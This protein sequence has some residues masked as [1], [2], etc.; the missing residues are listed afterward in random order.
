MNIPDEAHGGAYRQFPTRPDQY[1][2]SAWDA[3]L[4]QLFSTAVTHATDRINWY[5]A[6]ATERAAVAKR[7]RF[8]SL[9]LF[10]LGTLAPILLTFLIKIAAV[11]KTPNTP[12]T[13]LDMIA[14]LPLAEIGYVL[15][16]VAGAL[17]VF[18]QFFDASGSWIRFRQSQARLEVLL[19]DFRFSWAQAMAQA[20][21]SLIGKERPPSF[22]AILRDF[23]IKV[24]WLAEDET[25]Q[26]AKR[27]S[28]MIDTFDRNP[29]LK[30]SLGGSPGAQAGA[31]PEAD[32]DDAGGRAG[33]TN[34]GYS[35]AATSQRSPP[36]AAHEDER[37][38]TVNVRLAI[39]GIDTLDE[40]SLRLE[41]DGTQIDVAGDGFVELQLAPGMDHAIVATGQRAQKAVRAQLQENVTI[42][43]E[44]KPLTIML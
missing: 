15:L 32:A 28:Q 21:G 25:K 43:D 27:F 18:D 17:V 20:Q 40:G 3:T 23:V 29:N 16:A 35:A 12:S 24:E 19:A 36:P 2:G 13:W 1:R 30:V 39:D 9:L 33:T 11:G 22:T 6:K 7:I 37:V 42:E 31:G 34:G 8:M 10:A 38:A 26:W 14:A 44:D 4:G 5:D 41:V